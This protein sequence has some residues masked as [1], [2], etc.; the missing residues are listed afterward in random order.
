MRGAI[1]RTTK[2]KN[3]HTTLSKLTISLTSKARA[4]RP[5]DIWRSLSMH[6]AFNGQVLAKAH[7][8]EGILCTRL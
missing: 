5:L 3:K 4:L 2:S 6:Q 1:L 8:R 7:E